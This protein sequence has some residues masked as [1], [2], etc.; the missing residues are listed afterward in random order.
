MNY[1]TTMPTGLY[2]SLYTDGTYRVSYIL[3]TYT[4]CVCVGLLG[5]GQYVT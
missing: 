5:R 3:Y 1:S 2:M 4:G